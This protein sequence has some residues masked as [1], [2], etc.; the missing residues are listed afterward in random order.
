MAAEERG[1]VVVDGAN[2]LAG[3][4]GLLWLA[5]RARSIRRELVA[6]PGY[7]RHHFWY[8]WPLTVGLITFWVDAASAYAYAH[9]PVHLSL[10][11]R[12]RRPGFTSGGWLAVYR[13]H[14]GGE[15]WGDGVPHAR[16]GF[17]GLIRRPRRYREIPLP[18]T[19]DAR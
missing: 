5:W 2:R 17:E 6:S 11:R 16:R 14:H 10:W 7:L 4:R 9:Q 13:F 1:P 12:A 15:L 3:L 18:P 8:R 19:E